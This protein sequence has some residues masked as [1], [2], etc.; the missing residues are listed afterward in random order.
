[1]PMNRV[2]N[3]LDIKSLLKNIED[4]I[5]SFT[6]K[7]SSGN[8]DAIYEEGVIV[9]CSGTE[10]DVPDYL[11]KENSTGVKVEIKDLLKDKQSLVFKK[12]P[13][14]DVSYRTDGKNLVVELKEFYSPILMRKLEIENNKVLKTDNQVKVED[15]RQI[16]DIVAIDIDYNGELFNAE[17]IDIANKKEPVKARYDWE[18]ATPG[19]YTVAVKVVDVLGEE[20]F[21]TRKVTV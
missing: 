3:K 20:Y 8:E 2:L 10:L 15:Y 1:M 14:A 11:K 19:V 21:E 12:K 5:G 7:S 16:V 18:Y 4:K 9:I 17:I 13:E 6:V